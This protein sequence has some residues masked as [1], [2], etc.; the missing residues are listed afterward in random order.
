M[1]SAPSEVKRTLAELGL[2]TGELPGIMVPIL[3]ALLGLETLLADLPLARSASGNGALFHVWLVAFAAMIGLIA[4]SIGGFWDDWFFDPRY[5]PGS[6]KWIKDENRRWRGLLPSGKDLDEDRREAA[7]LLAGAEPDGTGAY[8]RARDLVVERGA[9]SAVTGPL[10][11]SKAI[12]SLI[13][14]SLAMSL[15]SLGLGVGWLIF[16]ASG[17]GGVFLGLA[18]GN[19]VFFLLAFVPY[20][21]LRVEHIQRLYRLAARF[22][23]EHDAP[24][25]AQRTRSDS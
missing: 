19:L 16:G 1:K 24:P 14:P 7:K 17:R 18:G 11:W 4:Y 21:Q 15:A 12:R 5:Q 3:F 23:R 2:D 9:W 13:F 20:V 6:G 22:A 8:R 25:A 10:A